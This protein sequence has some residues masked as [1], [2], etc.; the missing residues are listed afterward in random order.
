M[1]SQT[2]CEYSGLIISGRKQVMMTI[3][4]SITVIIGLSIVPTATPMT[5]GIPKA[6]GWASILAVLS[7]SN[8]FTKK[9]IC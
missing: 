8:T 4:I 1:I 6:M 5:K 2:F 3:V 7:M 9:V